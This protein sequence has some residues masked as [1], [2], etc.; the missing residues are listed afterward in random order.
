METTK[1]I[2]VYYIS[3]IGIEYADYERYFTELKERIAA[4]SISNNSEI[5]FIPVNSETRIECINPKYITN[6]ELIEKHDRLM[7]ELHENLENQINRIKEKENEE[8][9]WN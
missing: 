7:S 4:Q 6:N 3:V 9:N 8:N 5:I 2:L 1:Q